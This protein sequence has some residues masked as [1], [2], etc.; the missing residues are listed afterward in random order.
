LA[1]AKADVAAKAKAEAAAW[2]M[3]YMVSAATNRLAHGAYA[4]YSRWSLACGENTERKAAAVEN[5][6]E[7]ASDGKPHDGRLQ[8]QCNRIRIESLVAVAL[9][10]AEAHTNSCIRLGIAFKLNAFLPA[11]GSARLFEVH[12]ELCI[13]SAKGK[14]AKDAIPA[15]LCCS[16]HL[17]LQ[18]Y[19]EIRSPVELERNLLPILGN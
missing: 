7:T 8:F 17:C 14:L 2:S 5:R 18:H 1:E 4:H 13:E 12:G 19:F 6:T 3:T 15:G 9:A 10:Q 11:N 16:I